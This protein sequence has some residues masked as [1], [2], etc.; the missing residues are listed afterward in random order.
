[1]GNM[2]AC[3]GGKRRARTGLCQEV[4]CALNSDL[5]CSERVRPRGILPGVPPEI[6]PGEAGGRRTLLT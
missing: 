3:S 4:G 2:G 5:S 6:Q 1:M